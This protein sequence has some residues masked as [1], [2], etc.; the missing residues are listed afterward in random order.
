MKTLPNNFQNTP[1][2][3]GGVI[4]VS[5]VSNLA[6]VPQVPI[7]K[8]VLRDFI[9]EWLD[10][11]RA[12]GRSPRTIQ[13]YQEKIFKFWWW[14]NDFTG[15]GKSLGGHPRL[16]TRKELRQFAAYLREPQ[17]FRWGV[18]GNSN[19]KRRD[20][21]SPAS[22]GAYGRVVKIFFNW[23]ETEEYIDKTPFNKSIQF[24]PAHREQDREIKK[25]E[26]ADL[27]RV[28]D[29]LIE[30]RE[31]YHGNRNLA[32]LTFLLDTGVR[33]GELLAIRFP[34]DLDLDKNRCHVTG[35][36]GPRKV[37]F[38]ESTRTVLKDYLRV[39]NLQNPVSNL[40]WLCEDDQPL[41]Y[42]SMNNVFR[43]IKRDTGVAVHAHMFRHTFGSKMAE[44]GMNSFSLKELMGHASIN[45]T[46][47]Y[48]DQG[49]DSIQAEYN[50]ISP[51]AS[52][53]EINQPL[54]RRRG[55]PRQER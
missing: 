3:N 33:R 52:F 51:L 34:D 43:R 37:A 31:S 36:T 2:S 40:L 1:A 28:F 12:A 4:S 45:T 26:R 44:N 23:L 49:I 29:Y 39:R 38:G 11:N 48:V 50:S 14:W 5:Q 25:I 15:Y 32:M 16:I 41:S 27:K 10:A 22:I 24:Q 18:T 47:I 19:N 42:Q 35:K 30:Q 20:K 7:D 21:L 53:P 55:R 46:Q 8:D 54:K 6:V 13:D 9:F 17:A